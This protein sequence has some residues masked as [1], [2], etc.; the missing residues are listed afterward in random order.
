MTLWDRLVCFIT[1]SCHTPW[2]PDQDEDIRWLRR[3]R[4][5]SEVRTERIQEIYH[6]PSRNALANSMARRGDI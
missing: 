1:Q 2:N 4:E 6:A 3:K 5:E